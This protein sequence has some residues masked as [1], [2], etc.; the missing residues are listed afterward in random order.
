MYSLRFCSVLF[1]SQ[2]A[3]PSCLQIHCIIYFFSGS[4]AQLLSCHRWCRARQMHAISGGQLP[5][6]CWLAEATLAI[7]DKSMPLR[8]STLLPHK[9]I[10]DTHGYW[11]SCCGQW[12]QA[13]KQKYKHKHKTQTESNTNTSGKRKRKQQQWLGQRQKQNGSSNWNSGNAFGLVCT[14]PSPCATCKL[15]KWRE[16]LFNFNFNFEL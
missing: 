15:V 3:H 10:L 1:F 8:L 11:R 7:W 14:C 2:P 13:G 12:G 16:I 9:R 5:A 6:A 4:A